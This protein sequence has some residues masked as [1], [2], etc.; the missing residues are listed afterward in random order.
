MEKGYYQQDVI[1]S[2]ESLKLFFVT[3][4]FPHEFFIFY[5][6]FFNVFSFSFSN[7]AAFWRCALVVGAATR[8]DLL[9]SCLTFNTEIF[10]VIVTRTRTFFVFTYYIIRYWY[11]WSFFHYTLFS[12]N[13]G[14][15]SIK[16]P[17]EI[18][19]ETN[20]E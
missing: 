2:I 14:F 15:A 8:Q 6:C 1:F 20:P 18:Q 10:I 3:V 12:L 7:S 11:I 9:F 13:S 17:K 19:S 16:W 4:V 5:F